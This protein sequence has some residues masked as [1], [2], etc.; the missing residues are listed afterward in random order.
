MGLGSLSCQLCANFVC[1]SRR[2]KSLSE[3]RLPKFDDARSLRSCPLHSLRRGLVVRGCDS[4][5]GLSGSHSLGSCGVLGLFL[6]LNG[7]LLVLL[8]D[9][10]ELPHV[11][12]EVGA[13]LESDEKLGLLAIT[14]VV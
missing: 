6:K 7:V 2:A 10:V 12:E 11:L 9:L 8:S 14:P 5:M 3:I 13:S 1:V 4:H